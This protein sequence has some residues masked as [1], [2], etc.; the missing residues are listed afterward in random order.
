MSAL[1]APLN[2]FRRSSTLH[3]HRFYFIEE[4]G[5]V[6]SCLTELLKTQHQINSSVHAVAHERTVHDLI[7]HLEMS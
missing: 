6:V 3:L 5:I 4:Y 7:G 2:F 1:S